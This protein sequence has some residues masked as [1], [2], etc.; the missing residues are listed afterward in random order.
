MMRVLVLGIGNRLMRDDGIGLYVV[1]ALQEQFTDEHIRF[2]VGETDIDYCLNVIE[3]ADKVII[4]D[5]IKSGHIAGEVSLLSL[6]IFKDQDLGISAHNLHLF[7]MIPIFYPDVIASVIGIEVHKVDFGLE[8]S[9]ELEKSFD[10]I[11]YTVSKH[12][13]AITIL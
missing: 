3:A 9:E 11:V 12:I 13:Y 1:E 6:E 4:V 8:L 5:A 10:F 2:I 7:H